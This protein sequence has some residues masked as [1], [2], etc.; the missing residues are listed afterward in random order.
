VVI[1]PGLADRHGVG[2]VLEHGGVVAALGEQL[3]SALEDS[4]SLERAGS[5]ADVV[6]VALFMLPYAW[7]RR[8]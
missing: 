1:D 2:Y 8:S 5:A 4:R 3:R 6:V 7:R